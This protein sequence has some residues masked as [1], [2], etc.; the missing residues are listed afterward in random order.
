MVNLE[1]IFIGTKALVFGVPI[2]LALSYLLNKVLTNGSFTIAFNP[3]ILATLGAVVFVYAL[4]L[5]IM[6]YAIKKVNKKNIID[7]IRNENI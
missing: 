4:L 7:T 1:S 2:G 5:L 3:P 6:H